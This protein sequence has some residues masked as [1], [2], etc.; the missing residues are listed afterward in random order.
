MFFVFFSQS[1]NDVFLFCDAFLE[2]HPSLACQDIKLRLTCLSSRNR[3]R[4]TQRTKVWRKTGIA[5][6]VGGEILS[7]LNS[8]LQGWT[9]NWEK[10]KKRQCCHVFKKVLK[11]SWISSNLHFCSE[12]SF[13]FW[14]ISVPL[15]LK[16]V[17]YSCAINLSSNLKQRRL[18]FLFPLSPEPGWWEW[19][20]GAR[21]R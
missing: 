18:L 10:I 14:G 5:V 21:G 9:S 7:R 13:E 15:L 20:K 19:N 12:T 2:T 11:A 1:A 4:E 3:G 16:E 17:L 6:R 8:V